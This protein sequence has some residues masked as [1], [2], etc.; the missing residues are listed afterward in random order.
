MFIEPD[1]GVRSIKNMLKWQLLKTA[2]IRFD[3]I[4]SREK[5]ALLKTD[6]WKEWWDR[7]GGRIRWGWFAAF[8]VCC[9][10]LIW[11]V[12]PYYVSDSYTGG[13]APL[14]KVNTA[15]V[16]V[17]GS[18]E[19]V[20]LPAKISREGSETALQAEFHFTNERNDCY[21]EVRTAFA[22]LTVYVNGSKMYSFGA[23]DER[24]S[25]MKDPGTAF[26]MVPVRETGEITVV[27]QYTFPK[28]RSTISIPQLLVSNQSGLVRYHT[29]T[30][31]G[32]LA[33]SAIMFLAGVILVFVS[34]IIIRMDPGGYIFLW[35]GTF[36]ALTGMWGFSNCDMALFFINDPNLWYMLS[37]ISFFS[38]VLPL[39]LTLENSVKFH[40]KKPLFLLRIFLMI[41]MLL[42]VAL[43]MTGTVMF[44]QSARLYQILIPL[45]IFTFTF[46][47]LL[48]AVRYKNKTG[49]LWV[50]PMLI[51]SAA[52][53]AELV[54]YKDAVVYSSSQYFVYGVM[55]FGFF[56]CMIGGFQIRKS[57]QLSRREKEQEYR[58]SLLN[59]E[60]DEQ[61]KYQDT[62]LEH[63]KELRRQR[64]DYRHQLT[65]LKEFADAG[66]LP[67]IK[68]YLSRLR[69]AIPTGK[70]IRY[71]ENPVVNA[72]VGY[73][74]RAAENVGASVNINISLPR[75]LSRSVE[76]N[77][78]VVFGNLL[79]NAVEAEER[80]ADSGR[81]VEKKVNLSAVMHMGHL[82]IHME[83]SMTG[84]PRKW[85]HFY[86]SSKREEVGIGLT[87]IANIATMYDGN[88]EFRCEE[89][90]FISDVYL[91]V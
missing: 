8:C 17:N 5:Q 55:V 71:T 62:L 23:E 45:S 34:L 28:T 49:M 74:A 7:F 81:N 4:L 21:V 75:E 1:I 86:I 46:A 58:L 41:S 80:I 82:V 43:Q 63:E 32:V 59:R 12:I 70:D 31:G 61:K 89:N 14:R 44:T 68:E 66:K 16:T 6:D 69:E 77:L 53:V 2:G 9:L 87:S 64:H 78:C 3:Y 35:L 73:Y 50:G 54:W 10:I 76:Q 11:R 13:A 15:E 25:F 52:C 48:E 91:T 90:R 33:A 47:V 40:R 67:E 29:M 18:E 38:L 51:L 26:Y 79:E 42:C 20:K 19:T 27:L 84:K 57:I 37:Y 56:M 24:P 72:V 39:E 83:N 65:V 22:P 88:A 36:I 85:G 60:I 30:T